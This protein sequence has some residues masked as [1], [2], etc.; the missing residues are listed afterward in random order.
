MSTL[1]RKVDRKPCDSLTREPLRITRQLQLPPSLFN[2][3]E[4]SLGE[5]NF[6]K[7]AI[8]LAINFSGQKSCYP[9]EINV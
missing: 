4:P 1:P 6:F 3:A 5:K 7:P 2:R 8:I 9:L